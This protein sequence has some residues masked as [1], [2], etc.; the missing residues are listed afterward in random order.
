LLPSA[1]EA[2]VIELN[3]EQRQALAKGQSLPLTV[4]DPTTRAT[5]VLVPSAVYERFRHLLEEDTAVSKREVALLVERAMKEYDAND[6]TLEL[7]QH[8]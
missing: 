3:E 5:Y 4:I 7:Y 2:A 1:Q 8:D 6:P